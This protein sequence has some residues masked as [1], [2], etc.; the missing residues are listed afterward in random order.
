MLTWTD[1][2]RALG[3]LGRLRLASEHELYGAVDHEYHRD[4]QE[5]LSSRQ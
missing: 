5:A 3:T 2:V 1:G 4:R